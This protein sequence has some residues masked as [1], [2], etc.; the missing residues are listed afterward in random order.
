MGLNQ[1]QQERFDCTLQHLLE[2]VNANR[3]S[4]IYFEAPILSSK[5]IVN[6]MRISLDLWEDTSQIGAFL[7]RPELMP[8]GFDAHAARGWM[9][10]LRGPFYVKRAV[11][12]K[13]ILLYDDFAFEVCS[14]NR[15]WENVIPHQPDVVYTTLIPFDGRIISDGFLMHHG[16]AVQGPGRRR[17][18]R[19]LNRA[20]R[21]GIISSVEEFM[22][23]ADELTQK[24]KQGQLEPNAGV[25]WMD[26]V[27]AINE[28]GAESCFPYEILDKE[29][30]LALRRESAS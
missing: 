15:N 25:I 13:A 16:S 17:L 12:D 26:F 11:G 14:I 24:R 8:D 29:I 10:A 30:P 1:K 6:G 22:P 18:N 7:E 20:L 5:D 3:G 19:S 9:H 27:A 2:F 23:V 21:R 28:V 4:C